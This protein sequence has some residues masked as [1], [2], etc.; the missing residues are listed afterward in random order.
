MDTY[1]AIITTVLVI[2]QIIRV[3]QNKIQLKTYNIQLKLMKERN[4]THEE[5]F[6]T[7]SNAKT[8]CNC[9]TIGTCSYKIENPEG[10]NKTSPPC[11]GWRK[12]DV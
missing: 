1:L 2:T 8:C 3:T 9:G 11:T 6:L 10:E 4:K 7:M 12:K 5:M